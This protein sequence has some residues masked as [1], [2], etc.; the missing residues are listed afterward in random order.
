MSKFR[1][2]EMSWDQV[3]EVLKHTDVAILPIG[4]TEEHGFHLPLKVDTCCATYIAEKTAHEL[5]DK[6]QIL[7]AIAPPIPYG[8]TIL[9]DF[10]GTITISAETLTNLTREICV[11][12]ISHGF[13]KIVLL[14]GHY[15]NFSP[16]IIAGRKII[17]EYPDCRLVVVNWWSLAS[18]IIPEIRESEIGGMFHACEMET[19]VFMNLDPQSVNMTK[20]IKDIFEVPISPK[21]FTPDMY[22]SQMATWIQ[23]RKTIPKSGAMGDPTKATKEKGEKILSAVVSNLTKLIIEMVKGA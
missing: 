15:G 9:T 14:N 18:E 21:F 8:E 12:L 22:A 11:G 5:Y 7:V 4:A 19:S 13:R 2:E 1:I 6:H 3:R 17:Y 16:L 20:A 10:P 23:S